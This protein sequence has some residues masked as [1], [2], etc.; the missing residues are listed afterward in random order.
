MRFVSNLNYAALGNRL[1]VLISDMFLA[2]EYYKSEK[3]EIYWEL[4]R[5]KFSD[6]F[7]NKFI[8][9]QNIHEIGSD[10][11]FLK[12]NHVCKDYKKELNGFVHLNSDK[13]DDVYS[14]HYKFDHTLCYTYEKTPIELRERY[15]KQIQK[16]I[17]NKNIIEEVNRISSKWKGNIVGV[18]IRLGDFK[19]YP[20][21]VV[22]LEQF[23][24]IM[25]Q[26]KDCNFFISTDEIKCIGLLQERYG[27]ERIFYHDHKYDSKRNDYITAFIGILLLSRCKKLIVTNYSTYSQLAWYFGEC[28][29][30]VRV[31]CNLKQLRLI[32]AVVLS[33]DRYHP[34]VYHMIKK[35]ID[36][37]DSCPFVFCV[38][39]NEKI[40]WWGKQF[41][42]RVLFIKCE[43]PFKDTVM[44]LIE[45][46][47]DEEWIYW[48]SCDQYMEWFDKNIFEAVHR[49][50]L[51]IKD[52]GVYGV[53]GHYLKKC[54]AKLIKSGGDYVGDLLKEREPWKSSKEITIWYHQYLR[55]KVLK[56]IFSVFKEPEVAKKLDNQLYK[57]KED[58]Y[59]F[60]GEG[61]Y[62]GVCRKS[63]ECGEST[64]R[65]QTT[66]N[67]LESFK[68]EG[69]RVDDLLPVSE[70]R[71]VWI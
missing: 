10:Y 2:E 13:L 33:C 66:L 17:V 15:L 38:P 26:M 40:P 27:K 54:G 35:Y 43:S 32:R 45:G 22:K 60:L 69:I 25:D 70:K 57:N 16:L 56:H 36:N 42:D 44:S 6:L 58:M 64:S 24:Y 48:C 47:D 23:Y 31:V 61:K 8:E 12:R 1:T 4:I 30:D 28:K 46:V 39:Y 3:F 18:H 55:T 50:T 53:V 65:G 59:K 62:Y 71:L 9:Y 67:C 14:Y 7:D 49:E 63:S 19:K 21:R 52:T 11:I 5:H 41:G 68:K 29:A 20:D 51:K 34:Y 37:W